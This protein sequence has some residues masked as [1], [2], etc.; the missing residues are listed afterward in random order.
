MVARSTP[1]RHGTTWEGIAS[2]VYLLSSVGGGEVW[3]P[4][5]NQFPSTMI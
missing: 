2:H 4:T 3:Q 5:W 1:N